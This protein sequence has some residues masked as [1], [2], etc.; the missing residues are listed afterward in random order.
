VIVT[1]IYL[2]TNVAY[3][4]L[5]PL[6]GNPGAA[7]DVLGRGIAFAESDRVG[8]SA[9]YMIFGQSA[10]YIM[11][12]L[13]MVSTFGCNNG[14]ILSGARL[15]HAMAKDGLFFRQ[16][17]ELN[18]KGV[19]GYALVFQGVW[20]SVLCLSGKYGDL[21]EYATF[22]SLLFYIVTIAGV[23][24]LRKKEPEALRPY[25]AWGY[26]FLP[27]VYIILTSLI[28]VDLLIYKPY[29][30]GLGLLIVLAG[31]PVFFIRKKRVS[32]TTL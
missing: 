8:A 21:L 3:L 2:L 16:A 28:C 1:F 11:A 17:G 13:I 23:F 4:A 22:A 15:F 30:A 7:S 32:S 18:G 9:A 31:V 26:P 12:G 24:I 25:K 27:L 5:L 20:A 14:L 19:P 6:H 29:S 10:S